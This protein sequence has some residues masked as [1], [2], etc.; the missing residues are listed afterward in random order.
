MPVAPCGQGLVGEF[1]H[2][3][4]QFLLLLVGPGLQCFEKGVLLVSEV[5][6]RKVVGFQGKGLLQAALPLLDALAR[7]GEHGVDTDILD[8]RSAQE[9]DGVGNVFG[10]WVRRVLRTPESNDCAPRKRELF[11]TGQTPRL[12]R[13]RRWRGWPQIDFGVGRKCK[14]FPQP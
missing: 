10:L 12:F 8:S 5:V 1:E 13:V 2:G 14:G 4:I 11:R 9:V 7:N 6:G 3:G